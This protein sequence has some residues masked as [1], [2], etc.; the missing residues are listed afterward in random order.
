MALAVVNYPT[1]SESDFQ[2]IQ[3]IRKEHDNLFYGVVE[4]HFTLVFPTENI[5]LGSFT[6]HVKNVAS[7]FNSFQ[8]ISRCVTVG[9]PDF[10]DHAH[11]FM[12]PDEGFSEVVKLHDAFYT[13]ILES[14]LRLDLPFVPH[15]GVASDPSP[16]KCKNIVDQVN[17]QDFEVKGIVEKLDIIEFD[18]ESTKTIEQIV[19]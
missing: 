3:D 9:D 14:E 15:I 7:K 11:V 16:E 13:G 5:G 18:G 2:W 6:S 1:L 8:F 10:W 17:Q 4:P 19:L 12:I